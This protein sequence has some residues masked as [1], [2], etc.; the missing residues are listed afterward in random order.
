MADK[1]GGAVDPNEAFR[2]ILEDAG[3]EATPEQID[4][5]RKKMLKEDEQTRKV[6]VCYVIGSKHVNTYCTGIV[7]STEGEKS[8]R[9]KCV[10][11]SMSDKKIVC[12]RATMSPR[13][14]ANREE[15]VNEGVTLCT[16]NY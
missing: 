11:L 9:P 7:T 12:Q 13:D 8:R 10:F 16:K 6:R 4:N 1:V 15:M 2:K 3:I 5:V 14:I